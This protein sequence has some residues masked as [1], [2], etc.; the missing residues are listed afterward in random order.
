MCNI[1]E[2]FKLFLF[3]ATR[4]ADRRKYAFFVFL[5]FFLRN[6]FDKRKK[7]EM[8]VKFYKEGQKESLLCASKNEFN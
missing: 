3:L 5:I 7:H 2:F 6:F 8:C 4:D 1:H